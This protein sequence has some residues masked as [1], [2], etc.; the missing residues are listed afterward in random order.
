MH[1]AT[2]RFITVGFTYFMSVKT[3]PLTLRGK[4]EKYRGT[5]NWGEEFD[6][7]LKKK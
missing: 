4:G 1:G 7:G 6:L 3:W 5:G 2:M